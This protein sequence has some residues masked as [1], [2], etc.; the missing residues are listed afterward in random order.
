MNFVMEH[1]PTLSLLHLRIL[2]IPMSKARED[3]FWMEPQLEKWT[4]S[5]H[6]TL[7]IQT[8]RSLL[9]VNKYHLIPNHHNRQP[10]V[11]K[12]L[13]VQDG[14][15][16]VKLTCHLN[17]TIQFVILEYLRTPDPHAPDPHVS[18]LKAKNSLHL[19]ISK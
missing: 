17:K 19:R 8:L 4:R 2:D 1:L 6:R 12:A 9:M 3:L 13:A 16:F 10:H 15:K 11:L 14:T 7:W 5:L 18:K